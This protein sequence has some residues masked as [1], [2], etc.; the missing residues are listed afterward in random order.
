[1][2]KQKRR[3]S[4]KKNATPPLNKWYAIY[5]IYNKLTVHSASS[6]LSEI[7]LQKVVLFLGTYVLFWSISHQVLLDHSIK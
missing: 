7:S 4:E 5:Y 6:S 1:M 2:S 3:V